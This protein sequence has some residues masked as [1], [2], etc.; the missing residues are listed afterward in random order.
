MHKNAVEFFVTSMWTYKFVGLEKMVQP[1]T[2]LLTKT[3]IFCTLLHKIG[4][5]FKYKTFA[6][7][8][9]LPL[10]SFSSF[11]PSLCRSSLL[12]ICSPIFFFSLLIMFPPPFCSSHHLL[13]FALLFFAYFL[14]F[15]SLCWPS[16][17]P[18]FFAMDPSLS[19]FARIML[20]VFNT[21]EGC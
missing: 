18:F 8:H 21:I 4:W 1:R 5:K 17:L 2:H 16:S 12:S 20:W 19:I 13:L 10:D 15:Y 11:S 14:P 9:N 7:T 6:K 3:I